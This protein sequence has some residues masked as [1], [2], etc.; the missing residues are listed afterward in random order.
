MFYEKLNQIFKYTFDVD[1]N[2]ENYKRNELY[3]I[4]RD[5]PW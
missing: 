1:A 3:Q 4:P 5:L 2:K